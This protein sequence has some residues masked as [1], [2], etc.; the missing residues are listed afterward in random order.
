MIGV[1]S[2]FCCDFGRN[3][4]TESLFGL[5]KLRPLDRLGASLGSSDSA[6]R[7]GRDAD[8]LSGFVICCPREG[9]D[10]YVCSFEPLKPVL[11]ILRVWI[12]VKRSYNIHESID[13][14]RKLAGFYRRVCAHVAVGSSPLPGPA[15]E[16]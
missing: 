10:T 1:V 3:W 2:M 6:G 4:T 13:G 15:R 9:R 14:E 5:S 7:S 12:F 11:W 8:F 16:R